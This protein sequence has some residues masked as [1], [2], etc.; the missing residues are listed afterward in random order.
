MQN[1]ARTAEESVTFDKANLFIN[2]RAT[3]FG[4]F[5]RNQSSGAEREYFKIK[6]KIYVHCPSNELFL[7]TILE[8]RC[9]EQDISFSRLHGRLKIK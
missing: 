3:S 7:N 8:T 1:G 5:P 6:P 9:I 4:L 2:K